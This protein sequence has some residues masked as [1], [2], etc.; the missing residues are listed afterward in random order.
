[1]NNENNNHY[2]GSLRSTSLCLDNHEKDF[3]D[4]TEGLVEWA[5]VD[6]DGS[7]FLHRRGGGHLAFF[8]LSTRFSFVRIS[9]GSGADGESTGRH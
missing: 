3:P 9:N 1:M 7:S 4:H 5:L 6:P 8:S 2:Y